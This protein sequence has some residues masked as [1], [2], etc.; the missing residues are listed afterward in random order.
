MFGSSV[1]DGFFSYAEREGHG[2]LLREERKPHRKDNTQPQKTIHDGHDELDEA[3]MGAF[4]PEEVVFIH[5]PSTKVLDIDWVSNPDYDW[6]HDG[7]HDDIADLK[8]NL[9]NIKLWSAPV[10]AQPN[11]NETTNE[12]HKIDSAGVEHKSVGTAPPGVHEIDFVEVSAPKPS[13]DES[14]SNLTH[15]KSLHHHEPLPGVEVSHSETVNVEADKGEHAA[16]PL[17]LDSKASENSDSPQQPAGPKIPTRKSSA[18]GPSKV[19][20]LRIK[21]SH[22]DKD[23][24]SLALD[25]PGI[26]ESEAEGRQRRPPLSMLRQVPGQPQTV[27]VNKS[28]RPPV[29]MRRY[30]V[31]SISAPLLGQQPGQPPPSP[32]HMMDLVNQ[33]QVKFTNIREEKQRTLSSINASRSSQGLMGRR[34]ASAPHV[35]RHETLRYYRP[36]GY[37]PI[38]V[39]DKLGESGRFTVLR[40]LGYGSYGTVWMC[41]DRKVK[42]LRAVKVM[43]ADTSGEDYKTESPWSTSG[44]MAPT[45]DICALSCLSFGPNVMKAKA[46][47]DV[48]FL[49][50]V[51]SQVT[52]GLAFLHSKGMAHGDLHP[53]NILLQTT[54]SDLDIDDI[55][56]LLNQFNYEELY[57]EGHD[58]PGPHAPKYIYE[59]FYWPEVDPK[60][61]KKEI[62]IIDFGTSFETSDRPNHQT[63]D[64][65]LRAP[66]Q[67]FGSRPSQASDLW[68]LGCTLMHVLG[69]RNPFARKKTAGTWSPVPGWEDALGPLPQPYRAKWIAS[70]GATRKR[71]YGEMAESETVSLS[72][73]ELVK[74]KKCRLEE[75][76]TEDVIFAFLAKPTTLTLFVPINAQQKQQQHDE[77][78][79]SEGSDTY[80]ESEGL[81]EEI[82]EWCLPRGELDSAVNL[83]HIP[84][85]TSSSHRR[86]NPESQ[87]REDQP[88]RQGSGDALNEE[89]LPVRGR[90]AIDARD[91]DAAEEEQADLARKLRDRVRQAPR[92]PRGEEAVVEP[93]VG[94]EDFCLGGGLGRLAEGAHAG[95]LVP[96]EHLQH[97]D[98][99][100]QAGD[101][102]R[103][104]G[105]ECAHD[106]LEG[107]WGG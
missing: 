48:D 97:E 67:F 73:E 70:K 39:E 50:D 25:L 15:E 64:V 62:A 103:G 86:P 32:T 58:G 33:R 2:L 95:L 29:S 69:S 22:Y 59:S 36:G 82:K 93:L 72:S 43:Q 44:R 57:A 79:G 23:G 14:R 66:E 13:Q 3:A 56:P 20:Q 63:I 105:S 92:E 100:V 75:S 54:L 81:T 8:A 24:K 65:S 99:A 12:L 34:H 47:G 55:T 35:S 19:V 53:G 89:D 31:R 49:K 77:A 96:E 37:H 102:G 104:C 80:S 30:P 5:Q 42:K 106:W 11:G 6:E 91:A 9:H 78:E 83:T 7:E 74:A 60:Y 46:L 101:G 68:A 87:P 61:F 1:A 17:E 71:K 10:E 90:S 21:T 85:T 41:W 51:C 28:S 16:K 107:F 88:R 27:H 18:S 84:T 38:L 94:G 26:P 45:D 4:P 76:G 98:V 52:S 40:K